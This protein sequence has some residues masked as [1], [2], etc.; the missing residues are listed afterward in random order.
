MNAI[1]SVITSPLGAAG[2]LLAN[3]RDLAFLRIGEAPFEPGLTALGPAALEELD[4]AAAFVS[5]SPDARLSLSAEIVSADL[6]APGAEA[7]RSK[8]FGNM[9]RGVF[10][11]SR[12]LDARSYT[13]GLE[14]AKA[15]LA[16]ASEHL[17]ATGTLPPERIVRIEWDE[18]IVGG[19]P[20]VVL[21]LDTA[22]TEED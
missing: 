3:G 22:Q 1:T 15:R 4:R 18:K 21:R 7:K 8:V 6:E 9:L 12:E 14:L 19:T 10:G 5:K 13:L 17:L 16:A 11:T 2:S 20:R